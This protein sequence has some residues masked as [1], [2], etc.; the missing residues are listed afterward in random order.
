MKKLLLIITL[1]L[2][3]ACK[4]EVVYIDNQGNPVQFSGYFTLDGPSDVNCI[5]LDEKNPGLVDIES[6]C[7]SL[8]TKNPQ[9]NTLGQFPTI[10]ATN[11]IALG[12]EIRYT[13]NV[14]YSSG[15]DIEE[16]V[17]GSNITGN[18]RTDFLIKFVDEKLELTISIYRNANNANLNEIVATRVF[19]E[20]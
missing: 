14:N 17:S 11:L 13:R 20:L 10:T 7:Q 8:V 16:D 15:N 4:D 2:T 1:L 12:N 9:N 3:V 18:R 5:Y 6:D 19:K